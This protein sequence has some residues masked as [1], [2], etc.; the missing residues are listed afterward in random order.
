MGPSPPSY[1]HG[2]QAG[3]SRCVSV[4]GGDITP[5][6]G[7][8]DLQGDLGFH[9]LVGTGVVIMGLGCLGACEESHKRYSFSSCIMFARLARQSPGE[10]KKDPS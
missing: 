5:P 8:G 10:E 3:S 7:F 6:G 9:T 1:T 4:H 2:F